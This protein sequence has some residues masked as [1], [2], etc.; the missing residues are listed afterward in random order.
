MKRFNVSSTL[1]SSDEVK[2]KG[3]AVIEIFRY[4]FM[5]IFAHPFNLY[6]YEEGY[7]LSIP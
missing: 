2:S 3:F 6:G 4:L 7:C 5:L 1:K